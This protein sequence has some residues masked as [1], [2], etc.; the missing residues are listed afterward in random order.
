ML[1]IQAIIAIMIFITHTIM[2]IGEMH[3]TLMDLH[4]TTIKEV[5]NIEEMP[6]FTE[7]DPE[8]MVW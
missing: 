7:K 3:I 4:T 5:K 1:F 2:V 8:V 6:I